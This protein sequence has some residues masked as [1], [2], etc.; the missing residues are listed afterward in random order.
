MGYKMTTENYFIRQ[1]NTVTC[2]AGTGST[3][4]TSNTEAIDLNLDTLSREV[5]I[6]HEIDWDLAGIAALASAV[7]EDATAS[8]LYPHFVVTLQLNTDTGIY[9]LGSREFIGGREVG[10]STFA[11]IDDSVPDTSNTNADY[12]LAIVAGSDVFFRMVVQQN[13]SNAFTSRDVT[14][15]CRIVAQRAKADADTYAAILT[16]LN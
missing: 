14:A 4:S 5:L 15:H 2:P 12:P 3:V 10:I 9:N 11:V 8:G 16:G 1:D 7:V 13:L 6:V